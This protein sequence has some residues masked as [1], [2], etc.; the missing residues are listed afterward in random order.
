MEHRSVDDRDRQILA[1]LRDD[2]W[3]SYVQLG[4]CVHLS[5]SAVQRR[6]ERLKRDGVLLGASAKI[7]DQSVKSNQRVYALVELVDDRSATVSRFRRQIDRSEAIIEAH[8][9]TGET[10]VIL[11]LNVTDI[12]AYDAFVRR[13]F[14]GSTLV[15]RFKSLTSLRA[16]KL[17]A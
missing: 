5:A 16:L 12:D 8:Y 13:H 7:A 10:D 3:L 11:T 17:S 1:L 4:R 15:K 6:V 9:V 2:A 14:G